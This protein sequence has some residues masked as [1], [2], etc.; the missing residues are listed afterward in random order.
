MVFGLPN[1]AS[2]HIFTRDLGWDVVGEMRPWTFILVGDAGARAERMKVSRAASAL[3][4]WSA[5]RGTMARGRLRKKV[6]G[7]INVV[8]IARFKPESDA[9]ASEARK[10]EDLVVR[11]DHEY[12]N[13]RF[14]DAPSGRFRVHGVFE[15]SGGMRG[16]CVVQLPARGETAGYVVDIVALDDVAFAGA[17]E[18]GLGHLRKAG[19][20][21]ARAHAVM[22][23]KWEERLRRSGFLPPKKDDVR[24]IILHVLDPSH[25]IVPLARDPKRWF[26]TDGDRDAEVVS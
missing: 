14:V 11:R 24:P 26:F 2:A 5:W 15:P 16:W 6:F 8:P 12:L 21:V 10:D 3:V 22:G 25:P 18:A 17:L 4:P 19:A 1:R 9:V 7:K 20:S 13:W 23:S